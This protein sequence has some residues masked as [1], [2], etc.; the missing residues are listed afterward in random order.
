[1]LVGKGILGSNGEWRSVD[2]HPGIEFPAQLCSSSI[3][4]LH[5]DFPWELHTFQAKGLDQFVFVLN[6]FSLS[7]RSSL[8]QPSPPCPVI[9]KLTSRDYMNGLPCFLAPVMLFTL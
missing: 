2:W 9:W 3:H 8:L 4:F 5:Q 6:V 7:L 1:M